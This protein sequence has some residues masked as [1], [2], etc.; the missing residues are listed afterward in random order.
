MTNKEPKP[1][2]N[3]LTSPSRMRNGGERPKP[4]DPLSAASLIK[5][6]LNHDALL[7]SFVGVTHTRSSKYFG[8]WVECPYPAYK[9]MKVLFRTS[10][11]TRVKEERPVYKLPTEHP[12]LS[13]K[14]TEVDK[15]LL[16]MIKGE[17]EFEQELD[18]ER[19]RIYERMVEIVKTYN[20]DY[21]TRQT[22]WLA[23]YVLDFDPW[24]FEDL[25]KPDPEQPETYMVLHTDLEELY[26]W[27]L[28]DGYDEAMKVSAKNS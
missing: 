25:P 13:A 2:F 11:R 16:R 8:Y 1:K 15:K 9:G 5:D 22:R 21:H 3:P 24:P 20:H 19:A 23:N 26:V 27:V 12:V 28:N 18:L 6:P 14:L 7:A 4:L 10:N 17:I